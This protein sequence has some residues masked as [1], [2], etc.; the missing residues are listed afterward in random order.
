MTISREDLPAFSALSIFNPDVISLD[1]LPNE[2]ETDVNNR[3][4]ETL[5]ISSFSENQIIGNIST[6]APK[7]LFFSIPFDPSWKIKVDG[8]FETLYL[9]NSGFMAVPLKAG[10]HTIELEFTPPYWKTSIVLSVLG[11]LLFGGLLSWRS[12]NTKA[13]LEQ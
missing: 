12:R 6:S 5:Q 4:A 1:Y 10:N 2:L 13:N 8:K 11:F 9:A 7:A 3:R